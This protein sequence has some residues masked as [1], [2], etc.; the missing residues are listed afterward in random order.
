MPDSYHKL[1]VTGKTSHTDRQAVQ[2]AE[3]CRWERE[4]YIQSISSLLLGQWRDLRMGV[5][6]VNLG[7]FT[8]A[9]VTKS[10]GAV[11]ITAS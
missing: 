10:S 1:K 2:Y 9:P 11:C 6:W 3:V 7:I 4:F 8:T 5:V